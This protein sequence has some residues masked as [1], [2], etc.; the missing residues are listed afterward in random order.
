MSRQNPKTQVLVGS[1]LIR[2]TVEG[3]TAVQS[4]LT[5]ICM[6]KQPMGWPE[7]SKLLT[8]ELSLMKGYVFKLA[9]SSRCISIRGTRPYLRKIR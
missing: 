4:Y 6:L 3:N 7:S 9:K 5:S 2:V 8:H 1:A